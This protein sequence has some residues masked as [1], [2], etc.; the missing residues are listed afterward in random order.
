MANR[1]W[2]GRAKA[3]PEEQLTEI[4]A[5]DAA[6]TYALKINGK[7][8]SVTGQASAALTAAAL[9]AAWNAATETEFTEITAD[10][11]GA[12]I[13]LTADTA[14]VPFTVTA[15]ATGGTGTIDPVT[16]TTAATSPNH[17]DDPENWSGATLPVDG[18]NIYLA[19]SNVSI[20]YGLAAFVSVTPALIDVDAS[21][22]GFI[23]LPKRNGAG[24]PEYRAEYLQFDGATTVRIGAGS[25][26][27]SRRI[28]L[29]FGA[30]AFSAAVLR[31]G[32]GADSG[33]PAV[34]IKGT[35]ADNALEV[36]GGSVGVAF[37]GGETSTIK[38]LNVA[39]GSL[40]CGDGVTLNGTGS[41]AVITGGVAELRTVALSLVAY[42][43]TTNLIN[44][45][46]AT[47]LDVRTGATCNH[48]G[49][50]T[51]TTVSLAGVLDLS[52]DGSAVNLGTLTLKKQGVLRGLSSRV[53]VTLV[54]DS[55]VTALSAA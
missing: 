46:G 44:G 6:T 16:V 49:S 14:G 38:T 29:D 50:G 10:D 40:V 42:S 18:D 41:T 55:E 9:A 11:N 30:V 19:N 54:R 34:L 2:L 25:G 31:S 51:S 48:R 26:V 47:T 27:G 12:E 35:H 43:G 20:L 36:S 17:A 21:Y 45:G 8:V 23:G 28:K 13:T 4:T 1:T 53:T 39:G 52:G 5:N 22:T 7:S 3:R 24:Y 37:F 32:V 33:V 15:S